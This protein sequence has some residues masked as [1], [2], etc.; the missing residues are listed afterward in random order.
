VLRQVARAPLRRLVQQVSGAVLLSVIVD[1]E[2]LYVD[3]AESLPELSMVADVGVRSPL[4]S[5]ASGK[6]FLA[7]MGEDRCGHYLHRPLRAT[8]PATIT[9]PRALRNE[10]ALTR[11]HG[12]GV[13][14]GEQ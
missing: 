10:I 11:D 13:S 2:V 14:W 7:A 4:H 6:V 1:D 12:Y 3:R 9:D 5:T 8:T